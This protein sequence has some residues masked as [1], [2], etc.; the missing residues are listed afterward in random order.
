MIQLSWHLQPALEG[1]LTCLSK[2]RCSAYNERPLIFL[3]RSCE[4]VLSKCRQV[5][6]CVF[7]TWLKFQNGWTKW[8]GRGE[9][10]KKREK[11]SKGL[12]ISI[13]LKLKII[14]VKDVKIHSHCMLVKIQILMLDDVGAKRFS[15]NICSLRKLF[16]RAKGGPFCGL[17]K[18]TRYFVIWKCSE[19]MPVTEG[20]S[21]DKVAQHHSW[22]QC[23]FVLAQ[24]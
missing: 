24:S 9:D 7:S 4:I 13:C 20:S 3:N 1:S 11:E 19:G 10:R 17:P 6:L 5:F 16:G 14:V 23:A 8:Q 12:W 15:E 2:R 22:S 21:Q 18:C